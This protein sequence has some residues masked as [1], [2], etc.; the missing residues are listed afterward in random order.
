[1]LI[2][3]D[4]MGGDYAPREVIKGAVEA[5][6]EFPID[7]ALVGNKPVLEMLLRRYSKKLNISIIE[8][9]QVVEIVNALKGGRVWVQAGKPPE[10][11]TPK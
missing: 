8:A 11:A 6:R 2:A 9:S 5:A 4:A 10:E 1:M 3:V 7:I